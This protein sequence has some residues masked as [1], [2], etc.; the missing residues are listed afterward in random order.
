MRDVWITRGY[1]S[2]S[3]VAATPAATC[4]CVAQ[5]T[6]P[7]VRCHPGGG[8]LGR[9]RCRKKE[10]SFGKGQVQ[11]EG[12]EFWEGAG[13]AGAVRRSFGTEQGS[14]VRACQGQAVVRI[15]SEGRMS[16]THGSARARRH[17]CSSAGEC[18][19]MTAHA[20]SLGSDSRVTCLGCMAAPEREG[21]SA[22]AQGRAEE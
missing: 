12:G 11:E 18:R 13:A 15:R 19:G 20:C 21:M 3:H 6:H 1:E 2:C 10:A 17:V 9:G 8:L 7:C 16:G 5:A 22:Q 14:A 4:C